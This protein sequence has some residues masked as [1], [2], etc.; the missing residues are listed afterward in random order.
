MTSSEDS[1]NATMFWN[2]FYGVISSKIILSY[3]GSFGMSIYFIQRF[4]P[5]QI[6]K[7]DFIENW[8][9]WLFPGIPLTYSPNSDK[10]D[11]KPHICFSILIFKKCPRKTHFNKQSGRDRQCNCLIEVPFSIFHRPELCTFKKILK[12]LNQLKKFHFEN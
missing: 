8:N 10:D 2:W 1:K 5:T 9:L 12:R 4:L 6:S 11:F 3:F 7:V